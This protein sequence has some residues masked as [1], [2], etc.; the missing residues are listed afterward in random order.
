[1]SRANKRMA[2]E[3]LIAE[4]AAGKSIRE[5]AEAAGI[6]ERTA[7][8][9]LAD[10]GFKVRIMEARASAVA[11]ATAQL[12]S[13]MG[14]ASSVLNLLLASS[15][16]N[17][18]HRAAVKLIELSVKLN[19]ITEMERRLEQLER[20]LSILISGTTGVVK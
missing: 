4:L 13:G 12:L 8:R 6:A 19:T 3:K 5:A 9:R 11:S 7:H 17:I 16:P 20:F 15:D 1:V 10:A 14:K 2:D 18:Q